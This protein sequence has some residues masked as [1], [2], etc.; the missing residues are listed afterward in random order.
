MKFSKWLESNKRMHNVIKDNE[1]V[2]REWSSDQVKKP[3]SVEDIKCPDCGSSATFY[4]YGID[5][6]GNEDHRIDCDN[7]HCP[8]NRSRRG[9]EG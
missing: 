8:S 5:S 1:R 4:D 9:Y 2:K 7:P 3:L 6:L